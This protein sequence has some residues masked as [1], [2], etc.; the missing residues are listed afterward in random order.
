VTAPAW[1][2]ARSD[3]CS[4]CGCHEV[5][6]HIEPCTPTGPLG[7]LLAR[8]GRDEGMARTVAAHPDAVSLIDA[9]IMRRVRARVPF[10]ANTIRAE[11]TDLTP[12][13]RPVI[14]A[15]MNSLARRH[16]NKVGEE[17]STDPATHGKAVSIWL[18]K[19]AA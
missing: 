2:R 19:D 16:C 5:Q 18:A 15:E 10:S 4:N 14:G 17:P 1:L 7:L 8:Q 12:Q 9:A 6:G 11:L 13:E 3:R